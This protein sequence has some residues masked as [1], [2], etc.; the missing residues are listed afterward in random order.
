MFSCHKDS[1]NL[2]RMIMY[3]VKTGTFRF[4]SINYSLT[5]VCMSIKN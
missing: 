5:N 3:M 4:I 1:N 2:C